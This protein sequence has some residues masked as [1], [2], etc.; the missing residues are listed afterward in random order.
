MAGRVGLIIGCGEVH[1]CPRETCFVV[2]AL[3]LAERTWGRSPFADLVAK[4][5]CA[6]AGLIGISV[7]LWQG[8]PLGDEVTAAVQLAVGS[9]AIGV[10]ISAAQLDVL[11]VTR[12]SSAVVSIPIRLGCVAGI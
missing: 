2:Q 10:D 7:C 6:R 12:W 11:L 8:G 1:N 5:W 3:V 9:G 4:R